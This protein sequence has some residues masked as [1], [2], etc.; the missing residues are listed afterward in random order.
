MKLKGIP[1]TRK[2]YIVLSTFKVEFQT[3]LSHWGTCHRWGT[4]GDH[5]LMNSAPQKDFH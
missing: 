5:Q 1:D 3:F 4:E 2:R